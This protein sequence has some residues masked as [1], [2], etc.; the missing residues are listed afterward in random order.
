MIVGLDPTRHR[1]GVCQNCAIKFSVGTNTYMPP[2]SIF[3]ATVSEQREALHSW[4]AYDCLS[5]RISVVEW[6][7]TEF[8][9]A[10]IC[11]F[12][13]C[14]HCPVKERQILIFLHVATY[15]FSST[16]KIND[17]FLLLHLCN[18]LVIL[19]YPSMYDLNFLS[20]LFYNPVW[21]I[22][23]CRSQVQM[24]GPWTSPQVATR[25][26][27]ILWPY[28][29]STTSSLPFSVTRAMMLDDMFLSTLIAV[30]KEGY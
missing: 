17:A 26:F 19:I 10:L 24:M 11:Y 20:P 8:A 21:I 5:F 9:V 13:F 27:R 16:V 3:I 18:V 14:T 28:I 15:L 4:F 12:N 30:R 2:S 6:Q 29:F 22:L 25:K 1:Q 23:G 7:V